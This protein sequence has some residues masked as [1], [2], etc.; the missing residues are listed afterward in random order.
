MIQFYQNKVIDKLKLGCTL[1]SIAI[2]CLPNS[3]NYRLYP[4]CK[5]EKDLCEK[6]REDKTGEPSIV[7]TQ[8][9][10]FDATVG[11]KSSNTH[12]FS[13]LN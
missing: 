7:F 6:I 1:P 11:R 3:T 12:K 13:H 4:F 9:E 5:S 8:K 10:G 2:V